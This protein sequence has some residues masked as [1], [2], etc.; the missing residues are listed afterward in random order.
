MTIFE[1]ESKDGQSEA[2]LAFFKKILPETRSFPGNKSTEVSR[3]SESKFIILAY[4]EHKDN[5]AEYLDWREKR[6]DF[7]VLLGFLNEAPNIVS[8]D[9]LEGV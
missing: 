8:Y 3:L 5:L 7:S 6:G 4:W 9:V 1:F 2:L